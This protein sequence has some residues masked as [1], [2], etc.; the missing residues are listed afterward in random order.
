MTERIGPATSF[1]SQA[2]S[3]SLNVPLLSKQMQSQVSGLAELLQK[4]LDD[5]S[6]STEGSFLQKFTENVNQLN[7]TVE[8]AALVR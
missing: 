8:Q 7:K 5:P 1:E 6:L 3:T 2:T 4:V